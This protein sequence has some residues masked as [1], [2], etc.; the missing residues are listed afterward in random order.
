MKVGVTKIEAKETTGRQVGSMARPGSGGAPWVLLDDPCDLSPTSSSGN[1][2][3]EKM[4]LEKVGVL[5]DV[6][7]VH[8]E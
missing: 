3:P 8:E 1:L 2:F 5:F 6:R 7:K 4:I